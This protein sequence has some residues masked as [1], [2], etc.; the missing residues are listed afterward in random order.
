MSRVPAAGISEPRPLR[1]DAARNRRHLLDAARRVFGHDGLGCG[2]EAVARE[3]GVGTGTLYRHFPSKDELIAALI[4]DL[5][6]D[7]LRSAQDAL[8]R[9]DGTGLWEFLRAA[10]ALQADYQGLLY[11]LWVGASPTRLTEI[12]SCVGRLVDDA[13]R[14]GTLAADVEQPD[15][16][17][18]LH[19][20]RGVI[21]ANAGSDTPGAWE[22]YLE[23]VLT[24]L[25]RGD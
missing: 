5:S 11:R 6:A 10:G 13:H 19:G 12:R 8:A 14:H 9:G 7:V 3:A 16:V 23:L 15:I 1:Q 20:L 2:V 25:R 17:V 21:E 18:V 4:E 24:G 22:R